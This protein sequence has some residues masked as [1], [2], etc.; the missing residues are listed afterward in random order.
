MWRHQT[1]GSFFLLFNTM[2]N[3]NNLG[4]G[5]VAAGTGVSARPGL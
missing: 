3:W 2:L 1:Q 4:V 5:A